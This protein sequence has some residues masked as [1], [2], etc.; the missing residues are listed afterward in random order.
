M[1]KVRSDVMI[2]SLAL[3]PA[4]PFSSMS[5]SHAQGDTQQAGMHTSLLAAVEG[6]VVL[7]ATSGAIH[8]LFFL[9]LSSC[10]SNH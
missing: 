7:T 2:V 6:G 3:L 1:S 10:V 9:S 4:N 8:L 5:G